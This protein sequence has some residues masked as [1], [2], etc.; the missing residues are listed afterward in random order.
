MNGYDEIQ[1]GEDRTE[2][3]NEHRDTGTQHVGVEVVRRKRGGKGPSG[4]HA[5]ADHR[6]EHRDAAS[7]VQVPA[8]QVDLG[9]RQ[10]LGPN[11]DGNKEIAQCGRHRR[12]QEQKAHDDAVHG[13]HLVIGV[14]GNQVRLRGKQLE[15]DEPGQRAADKEEESDRNQIENCDP[16]MVASQQPAEK[17]VLL[18]NEVG[19]RYPG[20]CLVGKTD[21]CVAHCFT[22]PFPSGVGRTEVCPN[23]FCATFAVLPSPSGNKPVVFS[24][25]ST[26]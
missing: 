22:V 9:E 15:P 6:V 20:R 17:T 10:V 19:L 2:S 26:R 4:V 21:N 8:E 16:L 11:H 14:R 18:G 12:H 23:G 25:C 13:E 3:G 1:P 5:A 24:V 7:N